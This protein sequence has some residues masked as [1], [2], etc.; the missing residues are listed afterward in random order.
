[1]SAQTD[2]LPKK[3]KALKQSCLDTGLKLTHQRI[4]I[5]RELLSAADHPSAETLF[6][7]LR[8][9]LPTLSLDTVYRTLST[10]EDHNLVS[11]IQTA[12]S[13]A[14]FEAKMEPH[15]HAICNKCGKISDFQWDRFDSAQRPE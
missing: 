6:Q 9:T 7:R 10:F 3:L 4:E 15:H 11:R 2:T 8:K 1:M 12:E 14:R 5:Y 13:Q